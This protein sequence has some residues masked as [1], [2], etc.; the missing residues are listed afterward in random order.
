MTRKVCFFTSTVGMKYVMGLSG[1][2]WVGFVMA[3]MLGNL[4]L[5]VGPEAYN[6]YS[7]TL[8]SGKLVYIVEAA[9]V[10]SIL[11][12][13]FMGARL[14]LKNKCA[15]G[16]RYH[17]QA[18]GD[19]KVSRASRTMIF[20]G[21]I[22]LFFVVYHLITFKFGT[23]YETTLNGVVVR[24]I[25]R[26]VVEVFSNPAYVAGY[27]F[28]LLLLTAHLSHGVGSMFQSFGLNSRAHDRK[29][30]FISLVY[31]LVVGG[32]FIIQPIYV[33]FLN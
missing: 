24:D 22:I 6:E 4:L 31:A 21:A 18:S 23:Y 20:H 28:C 8:T 17:V 11:S 15:K 10:F 1:L 16:T 25:H 14:T 7:H 19:K 2:I 32:G 12:H 33:Y 26:L 27:I 29:I 9:L 5:F 3:H 30:K 13:V